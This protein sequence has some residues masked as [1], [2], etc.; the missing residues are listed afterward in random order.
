MNRRLAGCA[1]AALQLS[2]LAARAQEPAPEPV[3]KVVVT[4]ARAPVVHKLDKTVYDVSNLARAANG[5]AQ[6]VLQATPDVSVTADGSIAVR[7]NP[8][9]TILIDGKPTAMLAGDGEARA[10]ALQ[11]MAGAD[12]AGVEV[13]TNPSAGYNANGGAILNLVLKRKRQ[14]GAHGQLQASM[15]DRGLW[16]AGASGDLARGPWGGHATVALRHDGT[17]KRRATQVAWNNPVTGQAGQTSQTSQVFI[18]RTVASGALGVDYALD[19]A[20]SLSLST[21]YNRRQS[22]PWL[23]VLNTGRVDGADTA[24]HRISYGPNRQSDRSAS[25]G[26][27]RQAAGATLKATV[28]RSATTTLVDKSYR[29]EYLAP[30]RAGAD[31]RG[32]TTTSR[33]IDQATVDW[34]GASARGQWGLGLDLEDQADRLGNYQAAIDPATGVATP[35]RATTNDYAVTSRRIA[36]YVTDRLTLG[37]WEA[38]LGVRGERLHLRVAPAGGLARTG[39]SRALNPSLHLRYADSDRTDYT[40][41]Y[42]RSLQMPDA[43][44]YNP[45]ATYVDAQNLARGNPDLR[46]QWLNAA[47]MGVQVVAGRLTGGWNGFYRTSRDTV[48][49]AR[50]FAGN[51]L[52]TSRQNGGGARSAGVSGSL[53][54]TPHA[55]VRLGVDGGVYRVML[56]T[57]DLDRMVRQA[58]MAR[59]VNARATWTAVPTQVALDA[60]GQSAA[61]TPLGRTGATSSVNVSWKQQLTARLSV[62]VNANDI[63]DG[64]RRTY[65]TETRSFRQSGYDHFVARRVYVGVVGKF[66]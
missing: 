18:R 31:S 9:V 12:I 4:G 8:R 6:D 44:D 41:S 28:Q 66:G 5:S 38:L 56:A 45:H 30:A 51:V 59:Y 14:P 25:L 58:G 29:D 37:K 32:A 47:E 61:I 46:P 23:D 64:S 60:H 34:S 50:S 42:R 26:Y 40:F 19:D 15:A 35:D 57:P 49:D 17:E 39:R 7:G 54:W 53:D 11:T 10:V 2:P 52:V 43:R 62:T 63:F 16:N 22:R 1:L 65:S 48:T 20:A 24:Y 21:R 3:P 13:I 27:S 36:A 33:R 55:S